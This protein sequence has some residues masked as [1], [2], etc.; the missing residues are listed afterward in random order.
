VARTLA[1]E[2]NL[3]ATRAGFAR[4][5]FDFGLLVSRKRNAY[6]SF[7]ELRENLA[8]LKV[9]NGVH[10]ASTENR[11]VPWREICWEAIE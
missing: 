8:K 9:Q 10:P 3:G 2:M 7:N 4:G 1:I 5:V 11:N 6:K